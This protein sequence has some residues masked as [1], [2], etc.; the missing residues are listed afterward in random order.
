MLN[1]ST[2]STRQMIE[3]PLSLTSRRVPTVGVGDVA[4]VW[5]G[6]NELACVPIRYAIAEPEYMK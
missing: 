5:I 6:T 2:S 4:A 3:V 1:T